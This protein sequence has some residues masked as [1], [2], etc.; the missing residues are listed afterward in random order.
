MAAIFYTYATNN[1]TI[2]KSGMS[3]NNSVFIPFLN[4]LIGANGMLIVTEVTVQNRDT[5]QYFLTFDDLI[6]YFYFGKGLGSMTISGMAFSDCN[7]YFGSLPTLT[8]AIGKI[9]GT[10]QYISFGNVTFSAVLSSFTLRSSSEPN[11][12]NYIDFNLQFDV[13]DHS[14]PPAQFTTNCNP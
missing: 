6:T 14:L 2:F 10:T 11:A 12:V 3:V 9:R 13:I 1:Q 8:N 4:G 7:N 5:V